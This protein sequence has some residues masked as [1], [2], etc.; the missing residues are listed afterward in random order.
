[1]ASRTSHSSDVS[2]TLPDGIDDLM[3]TGTDDIDGTGNNLGNVI[4]GNSGKNVINGM[5]GND[6][7]YGAEGNDVI[8]GGLGNDIIRGEAD[9]DLLF[10]QDGTD[11]LYGDAGKDVLD[12]GI[13]VDTL[14]GGADDDIYI[15]DEY[16]D[17]VFE[18]DPVVVQSTERVSTDSVGGE[19]N[20][21]SSFAVLSSNGSHILFD[22]QASSLVGGDT[23]DV[24]DVF[25]KNTQTG[26]T[27]RVNLD[28]NG[29]QANGDSHAIAVSDDGTKIL[30]ESAASNLVGND[31]NG[32][33]D[34]FL[35]D[36][37]TGV[38]TLVSTDEVGEALAEDT[39]GVAL[40]A[41]GTK[42]LFNTAAKVVAN[43]TND[44]VDAFVKDLTT[45]K[46]VRVSTNSSDAE[47]IQGGEA[48]AMSADGTKILFDSDSADLVNDDT[49]GVR[50]SFVK[51]LLTQE[52]IRV[53]V[54]AN[55]KETSSAN[56]SHGLSADGTKVLFSSSADN[57]VSGDTYG[58]NDIFIKDLQTGEVTRVNTNRY[59]EEANSVSVDASFSADGTKVLFNSYANNLFDGDNNDQADAYV[60]D[61]VSGDIVRLSNNA[62]AVSA[63]G[64]SMGVSLSADGTK[65][66]FVSNA[67][68]IVND[69]N[70][71]S[72]IF[73]SKVVVDNGIDMVQ[74]S[75]SY[76]L[77]SNVENLV[78]LGADSLSGSGNELDNVIIGSNGGDYLSGYAGNDTIYGGAGND[79]IEG[80]DGNNF[81]EG[82]DGND[83]VYGGIG[84][85]SLFG[86]AGN[87]S[88]QDNSANNAY[89]YTG[90]HDRISNE[91]GAGNTLTIATF[92]KAQA[93][94]SQDIQNANNLIISFVDPNVDSIYLYGFLDTSRSGLEASVSAI[95]TVF[96]SDGSSLTASQIVAILNNTAPQIISNPF[97][98]E[99]NE[100]G[101]TTLDL[102]ANASDA[103]S[104]T[105][106][107]S[108]VS[109]DDPSQG[110][111]AVL[112]THEVVF[113]PT[114]NFNGVANITYRVSDGVEEVTGQ[115]EINVN[116]LNDAPET[117]S[118]IADY[119]SDEGQPFS[120]VLPA[121]AFIDVDGDSLSY[122]VSLMGDSPLPAWLNFND[123]DQVF[124]GTPSFDDAG[125]YA[126]KVVAMD[127]DGLKAEQVF[128]LDI[129]PVNQAPVG[130]DDAPLLT[131][132]E[133]TE[134][135]IDVLSRVF[136]PDGDV[137]TVLNFSP[138]AGTAVLIE[139]DQTIIYKP[140]ANFNGV[141][142][143][144]Y[145]VQD[146][147]GGVFTRTESII[148]NPI[149]DA[150]I[151]TSTPCCFSRWSRR[152][153][154]HN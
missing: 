118:P 115:A 57:L 62:Q 146:D 16:A 3:L 145:T 48:V 98:A 130:L 138:V 26:E 20:A 59:G 25:L 27:R 69:T 60:K 39:S 18:S 103:D 100:D 45:G 152:P 10:G 71:A 30:F 54:N 29:E 70:N 66:L 13:G 9:D 108:H 95:E 52:T 40:S 76:T 82:G 6:L 34:L 56:T 32:K 33:I 1:M 96:F 36:L 8:S 15:V 120:F 23:N 53:S 111:L 37:N 73:L 127:A 104:Q 90:G 41:D 75:V 5:D 131:T 150:P 144:T 12:G 113:T 7:L 63:S 17:V 47:V 51:D 97:I 11:V 99:V 74:S 78:L 28:A 122:T 126:I 94:F 65:A 142:G 124:S 154:L 77:P 89:F 101:T 107:L 88:L 121:D 80:G 67:T 31:T 81:L 22:S 84:S 2:Y 129:N 149:N 85:D 135:T 38:V 24:I 86:G 50:D 4:A 137:V 87:D 21:D 91:V 43:D 58:F 64:T 14:L 102:L 55:E 153:S 136:D 114:A 44:A 117:L 133:D 141:G 79:Y 123:K 106:I 68:D 147:K 35:K 139:A 143:I 83:T 151:L 109:L 110:T 92:T 140:D 105:L 116:S 148:V 128:N 93:S 49:N 134:L 19:A 112:D 125:S 42:V 132:N 72:D 61:L 46:V 119:T